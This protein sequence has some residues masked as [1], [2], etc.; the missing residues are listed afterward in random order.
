MKELRAACLKLV[1]SGNLSRPGSH[2]RPSHQTATLGQ[3]SAA[4]AA[5][6]HQQI[7]AALPTPPG[8]AFAHTG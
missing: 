3:A 5:A 7:L 6:V 8:T 4:Q 1:V 2:P